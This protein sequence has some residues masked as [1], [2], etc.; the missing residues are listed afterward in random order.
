MF[1]RISMISAIL[2]F[3]TVSCS[4]FPE[5]PEQAQKNQIAVDLPVIR[6]K[7]K[8]RIK[9]RAAEERF[10]RIWI[11]KQKKLK[12]IPAVFSPDN[13]MEIER[14]QNKFFWGSHKDS[15][16]AL[17]EMLV[18]MERKSVSH[19]ISAL[20]ALRDR[21]RERRIQLVILLV[22]DAEQIAARVMV[23]QFDSSGSFSALQCAATLLEFGLDA[24]YTDDSD[25]E[26]I[27]ILVQIA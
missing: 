18:F 20:L 16:F 22:P 21:L 13:G 10:L 14:F 17:P 2:L 24:S 11:Q 27:M 23:P 1:F 6:Q 26:K 8:N 9:D 19:N 25:M 15:F 12:R 4:T 3:F 7:L 5:S